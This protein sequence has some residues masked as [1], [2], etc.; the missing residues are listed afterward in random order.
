LPVNLRI[1]LLPDVVT[2]GDPVVDPEEDA[3]GIE[4]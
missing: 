2:V 4:E 1:V 3:V